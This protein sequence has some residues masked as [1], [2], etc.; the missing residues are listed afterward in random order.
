MRA[1]A[2]RQRCLD[3]ELVDSATEFAACSAPHLDA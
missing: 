1:I 3:G 2:A